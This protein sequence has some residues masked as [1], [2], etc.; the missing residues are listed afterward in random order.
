MQ[1]I[2]ANCGFKCYR[3]MHRRVDSSFVN[4]ILG[5]N[6]RDYASSYSLTQTNRTYYIY[7]QKTDDA[8]PFATVEQEKMRS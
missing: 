3:H 7:A 6:L 1:N 4:P 8:H 5:I 2:E